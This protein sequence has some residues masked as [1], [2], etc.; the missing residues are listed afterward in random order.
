[1]E[2]NANYKNSYLYSD[3]YNEYSR[4]K[5]I[6]ETIIKYASE[7]SKIDFGNEYSKIFNKIV[8][9]QF[10]TRHYFANVYTYYVES[11]T[12]FLDKCASMYIDSS[13]Q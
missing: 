9:K 12:N 2:Q 5:H 13:T 8:N 10:G 7:E 3:V 11:I 4:L 1:M 6:L